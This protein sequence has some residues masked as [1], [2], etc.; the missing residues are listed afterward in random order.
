MA[1]SEVKQ[2]LD[3]KDFTIKNAIERFSKKGDLFAP[4][5]SGGQRLESALKKLQ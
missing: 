5:L 2:G 1:W 4:V 3:P